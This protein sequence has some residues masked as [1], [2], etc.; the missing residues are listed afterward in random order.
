MGMPMS[1]GK[2]LR[3][4]LSQ[5]LQYEERD[6][7]RSSLRSTTSYKDSLMN[8]SFTYFELVLAMHIYRVGAIETTSLNEVEKDCNQHYV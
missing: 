2:V 8:G 1:L 4:L 6:L 5:M 3:P 7:G